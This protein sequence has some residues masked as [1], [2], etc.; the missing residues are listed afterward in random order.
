MANLSGKCEWGVCVECGEGG[1]GMGC[2]V[3]MG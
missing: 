3:G 2:R 1:R